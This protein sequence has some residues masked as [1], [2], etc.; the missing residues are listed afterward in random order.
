MGVTGYEVKMYA[1]ITRG[2]RALERIADA[3]ERLTAENPDTPHVKVDH[4]RCR[5]CGH[6][7]SDCTGRAAA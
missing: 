7:G 6:Y 1:D 3:L 4:G 2:A 5:V